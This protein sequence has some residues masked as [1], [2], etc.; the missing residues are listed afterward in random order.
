MKW[1][2]DQTPSPSL[3]IAREQAKHFWPQA[4][5]YFDKLFYSLCRAILW[6]RICAQ[7]SAIDY[8]RSWLRKTLSLL[9]WVAYQQRIKTVACEPPLEIATSET[10]NVK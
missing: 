4:A 10:P 2:E 7:I 1:F 6:T 5:M 9:P 8:L 3:L